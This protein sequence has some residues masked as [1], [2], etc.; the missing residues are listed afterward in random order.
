MISGRNPDDAVVLKGAR[1]NPLG[2]RIP[3]LAVEVA[4]EGGERRDYE[5]RRQEYLA[6]G[7]L[8]SWIVDPKQRK[9]TV[10]LRDGDVWVERVFRDDQVVESLVLP[11]FGARVAELWAA[12]DEPEG[13]A[14]GA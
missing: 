10:L 5:T 14:P 12:D 9:V 11:G 7:L 1:K 2:R 3:A 6:F 8:E 4:S 13:D